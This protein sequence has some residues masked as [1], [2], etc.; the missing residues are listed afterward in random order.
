MSKLISIISVILFSLPLSGQIEP[1]VMTIRLV[2]T[3]PG[4]TNSTSFTIPTN[5][6]FNTYNYS[7]DWDYNGTFQA[8]AQNVNVNIIH[9]YGNHGTYQI[10]IMPEV[11]NGFP[12][13]YFNY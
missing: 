2:D 9:D 8:D 5:P 13:I 10:A 1:F 12:A 11:S 6:D 4:E 3:I 7:V